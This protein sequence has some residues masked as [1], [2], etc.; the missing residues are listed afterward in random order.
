[1]FQFL[2]L[3]L[4]LIGI[5]FLGITPFLFKCPHCGKRSNMLR[6]G[7]GIW[8]CWRCKKEW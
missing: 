6:V 2:L 7:E 8:I 5:T 3:A 4:L 1:M